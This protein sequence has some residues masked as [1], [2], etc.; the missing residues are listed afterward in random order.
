MFYNAAYVPPSLTGASCVPR[1]M[2]IPLSSTR[3]RF[4]LRTVE[5]RS[6][7]GLEI[8]VDIEPD[9]T[10]SRVQR[11]SQSKHGPLSFQT[12]SPACRWRFAVISCIVERE[13]PVGAGK[14]TL[15]CSLIKFVEEDDC[16]LE[17]IIRAEIPLR[18]T[19]KLNGGR[20]YHL[21]MFR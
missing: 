10:I 21:P 12:C 16:C 2:M 15:T 14:R 4:A 11:R 6:R 17:A 3:I 19:S 5:I 13:T 9:A 18:T 1:S 7:Y 20:P 8:V